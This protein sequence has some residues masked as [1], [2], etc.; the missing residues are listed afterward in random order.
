M[1]ETEGQ[2]APL[3]AIEYYMQGVLL[4]PDGFLNV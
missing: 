4:L 2:I 1:K 3:I